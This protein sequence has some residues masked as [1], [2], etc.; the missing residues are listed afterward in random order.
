MRVAEAHEITFLSAC[1][2]YRVVGFIRCVLLLNTNNDSKLYPMFLGTRAQSTNGRSNVENLSVE[3]G[4]KPSV[5]EL[6]SA[7]LWAEKENNSVCN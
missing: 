1:W 4:C 3:S 6:Y 5:T 2:Q 7:A